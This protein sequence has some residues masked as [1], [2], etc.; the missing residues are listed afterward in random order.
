VIFRAYTLS[1]NDHVI[2]A[3]TRATIQTTTNGT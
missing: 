2:V 3:A 1:T